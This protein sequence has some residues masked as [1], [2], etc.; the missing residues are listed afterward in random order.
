MFT[1]V[2]FEQQIMREIDSISALNK[3]K[4]INL[5]GITGSGGGAGTPPGGFI[6]QLA[7][8]Y[9]AFDMTEDTSAD[10]PPSGT[11]LLHNLNRIR[12][13]DA[14]G[15]SSILR[16]HIASGVGILNVSDTVNIFENTA[17]I[18]FLNSRIVSVTD[19]EINV[20]IIPNL[21]EVLVSG[22]QAYRWYM[23]GGLV[24]DVH[25]FDGIYQVRNELR[26][27]SVVCFVDTPGSTTSEFDLETSS[28]GLV[29]S[30]IFSSTYPSLAS[31]EQLSVFNYAYTLSSGLLLRA[32]TRTVAGD[33]TNLSLI[34]LSA[35]DL[36]AG[37]SSIVPEIVGHTDE[38]LSNNGI[39]NIWRKVLWSDVDKT[40]S[41]LLDIAN[42]S[43]TLLSGIGAYTHDEI[44]DHINDISAI[45]H[46]PTPEPNSILTADASGFL[47]WTTP[48]GYGHTIQ[49]NAVDT[50]QRSRL[51]F[52]GTNIEIID[53]PLNDST[54]IY[55]AASGGGAGTDHYVQLDGG[56]DNHILRTTLSFTRLG[57]GSIDGLQVADNPAQDRTDVYLGYQGH[58]VFDETNTMSQRAGLNFV[59]FTV[60]DD[61][62]ND[63]TQ[64]EVPTVPSGLATAR[65]VLV[66]GTDTLG[67][68]RREL[69][70]YNPDM[71]NL[72]SVYSDEFYGSLDAKWTTS[73]SDTSFDLV[74][75]ANGSRHL[76]TTLYSGLLALQGNWNRDG[77][78]FYQAFVPADDDWT[79]VCKVS[80][81]FYP[82]QDD[83]CF[84]FGIMGADTSHYLE[85]RLGWSFGNTVRTVYNDGG[86]DAEGTNIS[87][88]TY[89]PV[90]VMLTKHFV[91]PDTFYSIFASKDGVT[92]L[93]IDL[94][95]Q[96]TTLTTSDLTTQ[97]FGVINQSVDVISSIDFIRY[98]P[99]FAKF[100]IGVNP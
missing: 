18:N 59:G 73:A 83:S 61:A 60:I 19:T 3:I 97:Y 38:F 85:A 58:V 8:R 57:G 62:I 44:D 32:A 79:L 27:Q 92:W 4:A 43:H 50:P 1:A 35:E 77:S 63:W 53:S 95:R 47:A 88:N 2:D 86:G 5:G 84:V 52:V 78:D 9:V 68:L 69:L 96:F 48:S 74:Q 42:R 75:T 39:S 89:G 25:G 6:G 10:I 31:G 70:N 71:T 7:Q 29:W 21:G 12:S 20:E 45:R 40:D 76:S 100:D 99:T 90:Y 30:T 82:G 23:D 87:F 11:S 98:F 72:V 49:L 41:S 36:S 15:D 51:N 24:S 16:R 54:D 33:A 22:Y 65:F 67:I 26:V 46:I 34:V 37:I 56:V 28:D 66:S 14:L 93:P 13:G 55:I 80:A 94:N 17:Q 81:G 91:N 64:I